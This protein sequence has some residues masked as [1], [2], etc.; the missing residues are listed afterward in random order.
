MSILR[1]MVMGL[2]AFA[3]LAPSAAQAFDFLQLLGIHKKK[4]AAKAPAAQTSQ[5]T[6]GTGYN[7]SRGPSGGYNGSA[8]KIQR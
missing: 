2:V 5:G 8:V 6:G 4:P 7:G 1:R 3:L